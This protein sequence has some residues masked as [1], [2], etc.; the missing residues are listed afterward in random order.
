MWITPAA[1]GAVMP[2]RIVQARVSFSPGN[3]PPRLLLDGSADVVKR[4]THRHSTTLQSARPGIYHK[5]SRPHLTP[6]VSRQ[7]QSNA[8]QEVVLSMRNIRA[9]PSD[10]DG[11]GPNALAL[12][13][14]EVGAQP[15]LLVG[16]AAIQMGL[17]HSAGPHRW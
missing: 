4:A 10:Q 11:V 8:M 2:A 17:A 15:E 3:P 12:T 5:L 13:G 16:F 9:T 6:S 1:C 7:Q 14:G